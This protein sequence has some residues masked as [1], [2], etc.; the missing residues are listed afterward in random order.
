LE[1]AETIQANQQTPQDQ[2]ELPDKPM[3]EVQADY[4]A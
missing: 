2:P 3:E 1:I 4:E